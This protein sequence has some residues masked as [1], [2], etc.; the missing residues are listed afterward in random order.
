MN[1]PGFALLLTAAIPV[2]AMAE[3]LAHM[4]VPFEE[5][6]HATVVGRRRLARSA[7]PW[8]P[9]WYIS[10]MKWQLPA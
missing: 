5:E 9:S 2:A 1:N 3:P 10:L 8:G 4:R 6:T 7:N